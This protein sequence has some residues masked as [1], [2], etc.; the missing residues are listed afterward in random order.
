MGKYYVYIL[1]NK[2]RSTYVGFTPGLLR[3][4]TDHLTGSNSD[5]AH[6]F[7]ITDLVYLEIYDDPV[8]AI[9][10]EKQIKSYRREKKVR[11]VER[12][13]PGWLALPVPGGQDG[14]EAGV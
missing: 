5:Y 1:A 11:L 6:R 7:N 10:R 13:N 12:R 14:E 9:R 8:A 2:N 4:L 3:R